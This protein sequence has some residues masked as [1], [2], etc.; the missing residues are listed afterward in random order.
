MVTVKTS[1]DM[2]GKYMLIDKFLGEIKG[3]KITES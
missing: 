3:W 2:Y 1:L